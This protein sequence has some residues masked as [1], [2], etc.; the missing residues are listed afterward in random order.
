[1]S[2]RI[3]RAFGRAAPAWA[4]ALA[5]ALL[6]LAPRPARASTEEFS[7][8]HTVTQEEDDESAI[9]HLLTAPPDGWRDDW[10]HSTNAFRTAQGCLTSGQWFIDSRLKLE[11]ALGQR[12]RFGLDY[13][14]HQADDGDWTHA[15]LVFRWPITR[16]RISAMFRP[17]HDKSRQDFGL[18][19]GFGADTTAVSL[20]AMWVFEDMFNNLWAWRQTRVGEVSEPYTRHPYEPNLAFATRGAGIRTHV[21]GAWLTPSVKQ[22]RVAPD[23]PDVRVA[24]LW[25]ARAAGDLE[26]DALGTTWHAGGAVKQARSVE[27]AASPTGDIGIDFRRQ[28][29]VVGGLDHALGAHATLSWRW[30]YMERV[31]DVSPPVGSGHFGAIDRIQHVELHGTF[32]PTVGWRVG[33]MHDHINVHQDPG[34]SGFS[35][36]TRGENRL[37]LGLDLRFGQVR[38]TGVEGLELDREPYDVAH[39]HDKGFLGLQS[40]F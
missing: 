10:E 24:Q 40:R 23:S 4:P 29:R 28:W 33:W 37:Y 32:R 38:A 11:T 25:G 17:Y 27:D 3:R 20:R 8:F 16:G 18:G 31:E 13:T 6:A 30:V 35:W 12:A 7:T 21:D 5:L 36:G 19:W 26:F 14:D 2:A 22:V 39:H 1:M 9:D 15:D 34:V